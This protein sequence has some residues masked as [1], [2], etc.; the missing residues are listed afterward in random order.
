METPN[1]LHAFHQYLALK[2]LKSTKQRDIIVEEF[3]KTKE[4]ID[5][6]ALYEKVRARSTA[7]GYATVYRTMKLLKEGGLA[8]ERH[9]G[10]GYALY[11]PHDKD[12]H[13]H[14]ICLKCHKILEFENEAIEKLQD[15]VA[16]KYN[17]KLMTH[18]HELYGHCQTCQE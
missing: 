11:E 5:V 6:E 8:S 15:V 3:L 17:F 13:D 7:I 14:L 16:K 2:G 4:H 1:E 18:K 10:H 12:H 9:F